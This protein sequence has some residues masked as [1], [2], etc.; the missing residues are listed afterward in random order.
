MKHLALVLGGLGAATVAVAVVAGTAWPREQAAL[1]PSRATGASGPAWSA[2]ATPA[3]AATVAPPNTTSTVVLSAAEAAGLQAMVEEEKIALDLYTAFGAQYPSAV[4]DNIAASEASHVAAVRTLLDRYGVVDP[5][6][7]LPAGTFATGAAQALYDQLLAAG[8]RDELAALRVG[9]TV[10]LDDIAKLD[11]STDQAA[12][13]DI[14]R[15][16]A[17]LRTASNQHLS[18]FQRQVDART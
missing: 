18:A 12:Q 13:A 10:E 1:G 15:V 2:P 8:L 14:Q 11:A 6:A 9:V 7:G 17:N 5:T 16:Y 4:F 3:T